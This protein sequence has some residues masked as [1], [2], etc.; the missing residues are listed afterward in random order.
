MT[1]ELSQVAKFM[2]DELSGS[3]IR[4]S[5]CNFIDLYDYSHTLTQWV[6]DR[7]TVSKSVSD[8]EGQF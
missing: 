3:L 6:S 1:G 7:V 4:K 5:H 2:G 8:S